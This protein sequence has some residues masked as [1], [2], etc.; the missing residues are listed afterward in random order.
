MTMDA[1][2][3]VA[4]WIRD[5]RPRASEHTRLELAHPEPLDAGDPVPGCDC[6][7]CLTLA[8]GGNRD[9]VDVARSVVADLQ[10]LPLPIQRQ[11]A[12]TWIDGWGASGTLLP[13]P[14]VLVAKAREGAPGT[15]AANRRHRPGLDR[16]RLSVEEARAVPLADVVGRLGL[17]EPTG[18][19]GEPRILCPLHDDSTPS[20]RLNLSD[21]LWYCDPCGIGG[22]GIEL[23]RRVRGVSFPDAVREL[24]RRAA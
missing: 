10:A 12:E 16:S 11:A 6:L 1:P 9:A 18:R 13:S 4:D 23:W 14:G 2:D 22:D 17:G 24:T 15:P 19:W 20:L 8:G 21:G 3:L 7:A 5:A